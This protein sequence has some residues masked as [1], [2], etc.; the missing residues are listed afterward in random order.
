MYFDRSETQLTGEVRNVSV[1][2][3]VGVSAK[4]HREILGVAEG[5]KED[6]AG[7]SGFPKHLKERA[8]TGIELFTSDACMGL[9]ESLDDFYPEA[10]W[11][12]CTVHFYRNIYSF[13][14]KENMKEVT[15][16]LK[17]I[18]ASED[19]EAA[20]DKAAA[21]AE[22]LRA[23]KLNQAAKI[24][25]NGVAETLSYFFPFPALT[26]AGSGQTIPLSG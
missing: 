3:S 18:H 5:A 8:L 4:R 24:F 2:V 25:Q 26:G 13:V 11:Q 15:I 6:K 14:P 9:I 20:T 7:W 12:W 21:V 22:K 19:V 10:K 23:M 1:L 16:M 17:A